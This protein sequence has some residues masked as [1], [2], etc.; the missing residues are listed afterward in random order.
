M[1]LT[2]AASILND[3]SLFFARLVAMC[4]VF[5]QI[6]INDAILSRYVP[7]ELRGRKL[8]IK[9]LLNLCVGVSVLP[10]S[11]LIMLRGCEFNTLF[12]MMS[13]VA[14]TIFMAAVMLPNRI[15]ED[16]LDKPF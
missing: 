3:W 1:I 9:F 10:I 12:I 8:S 6:P 16:R 7:D 15:D 13:G 4:F 11:S 5:G 2:F 14:S